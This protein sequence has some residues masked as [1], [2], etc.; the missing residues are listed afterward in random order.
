MSAPA[1]V[2]VL[3]LVGAFAQGPA[4]PQARASLTGHTERSRCEPGLPIGLPSRPVNHV[5]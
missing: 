2:S 4:A 1:L 5:A 3:F